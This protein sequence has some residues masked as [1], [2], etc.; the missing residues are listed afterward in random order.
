MGYRYGRGDSGYTDIMG[1]GRV[2]KDHPRVA[3]Y[4][5]VDELSAAIG[6][7]K[8]FT[9]DSEI[10]EILGKVQE[11]LFVIAANLSAEK[12]L[13]SLP[14]VGDEM[15]KWLEEHVERFERELPP[16]R[17]F[18]FAGGTQGAA[19]LHLA[20]T[21]AR[22]AE[23]DIVALASSAHVEPAILAYINR[24]S[25]LL[26]TLARLENRRAGVGDEEWRGR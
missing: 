16:L 4:G 5:S 1:G 7:A 18:I 10:K 12:S 23:R 25:T 20:R 3:A 11:H 17:R 19:F 21:V 2:R 6:V 13:E 15:V 22:R 8:T 24:L 9:Q 14:R 26:F